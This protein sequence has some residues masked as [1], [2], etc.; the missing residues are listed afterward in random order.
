MSV[1]GVETIWINP[2]FSNNL[3]FRM[4]N[5]HSLFFIDGLRL[6]DWELGSIVDS[7]VTSE[8]FGVN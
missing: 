6:A 2:L 3:I 5:V 4:K 8:D 1:V 7:E